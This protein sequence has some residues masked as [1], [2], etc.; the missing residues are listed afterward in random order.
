M[1]KNLKAFLRAP[2]SGS[3]CQ[4]YQPQRSAGRGRKMHY[5]QTHAHHRG[6]GMR[7]HHISRS[8]RPAAGAARKG[9]ALPDVPQHLAS[10]KVPLSA[11]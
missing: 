10:A 4:L 3:G 11:S 1:K 7:L 5:H 8:N 2:A 9:W 6:D